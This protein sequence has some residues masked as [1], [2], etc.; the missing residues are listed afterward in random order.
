MKQ[1]LEISQTTKRPTV[2]TEHE[3][4][5]CGEAPQSAFSCSQRRIKRKSLEQARLPQ[6][7]LLKNYNIE[8]GF[9]LQVKNKQICIF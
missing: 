9:H 7:A 2:T 1:T 3:K 4:A 5:D 8:N 6:Q